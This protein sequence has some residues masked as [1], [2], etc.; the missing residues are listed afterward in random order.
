MLPA[1]L[2]FKSQSVSFFYVM[3]SPVTEQMPILYFPSSSSVSNRDTAQMPA[4][5]A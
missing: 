5:G 2:R 1:E 4:V 3:K